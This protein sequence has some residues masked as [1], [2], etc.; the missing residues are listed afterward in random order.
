MLHFAAKIPVR[1]LRT[2]YFSVSA[3]SKA[4]CP[5]IKHFYILGD[6][7]PYVMRILLRLKTFQNFPS[8]NIILVVILKIFKYQ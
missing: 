3:S 4:P 1:N 5:K 8:I 6:D 2:S 7:G